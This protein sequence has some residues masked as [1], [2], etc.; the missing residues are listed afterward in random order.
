MDT[1]AFR[2]DL[3]DRWFRLWVNDLTTHFHCLDIENIE[4]ELSNEVNGLNAEFGELMEQKS[5]LVS[6]F[7]VIW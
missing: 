6:S 7:S 2:S 5:R 1:T 3:I 4:A